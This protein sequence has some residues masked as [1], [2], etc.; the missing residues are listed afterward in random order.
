MRPS[1]GIILLSAA[2]CLTG[3]ATVSGSDPTAAS[4]TSTSAPAPSVVISGN[5]HGGLAPVA[6][7]HVYLLAVGTTGYGGPSLS[8]LNSSVTGQSDATGA[9]VLTDNVGGYSI[10]SSAIGCTSDQYTYLLATGGNAGTGANSATS[11][12]AAVGPCVLGATPVTVWINEVTTVGTAYALAGFATDSLHISSSGSAAALQGVKNAFRVVPNLYNPASGQALAVTPNG[13]GTV[14]QQTINTVANMLAACINTAAPS[15]PAC[16]SLFG[17]VAAPPTISDTASAAIAIAHKPA[18]YVDT[19]FALQA[20]GGATFQPS[21]ATAP[22]SLILPIQYTGGA[23]SN[24]L[25]LAVDA[26]GN[27]WVGNGTDGSR[28][29]FNSAGIPL[30]SA[31]F[32]DGLTGSEL[33]VSIDSS[34]DAWALDASANGISE[35]SASGTLVAPVSQF[36]AAQLDSPLGLAFDKSG[37]LWVGDDKGLTRI[38]S[39]GQIALKLAIPSS[40][41][42]GVGDVEIDGL[43]NVWTTNFDNNQLIKLNSAGVPIFGVAGVSGGGLKSPQGI[44]MDAQNN[45]WVANANGSNISKFGNNGEPLSPTGFFGGGI[46]GNRFLAIDGAGMVWTPS[47]NTSI[48]SEFDPSGNPIPATGF[49]AEPSGKGFWG[50]AIDGSGNVWSTA[51]DGALVQLVGAAAPVLTPL[52]TAA[53]N[54]M[55]GTRP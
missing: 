33:T 29:A 46:S 49:A 24:P 41:G 10:L 3:C 14:P 37:M 39:N 35:L 43:G 34:S 2:L 18:A 36:A 48:I 44:A 5:V 52:T 47:S 30:G 1:F 8:V 7:A 27:V 9:Y 45:V 20:M 4:N 17:A 55:L 12:I 21:L 31:G 19:L 25:G 22:T 50:V 54:N 28:N 32:T 42:E 23:L 13:N 15:A 38:N 40:Q 26:G 16:L 11:M 53:A 51:I 6:G